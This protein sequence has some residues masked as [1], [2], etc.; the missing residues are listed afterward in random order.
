MVNKEEQMGM[1]KIDLPGPSSQILIVVGQQ[2]VTLF[3]LA[4]TAAAAAA[5]T[6]TAGLCRRNSGR[7]PSRDH[8]RRRMEPFA[9][10]YGSAHHPRARTAETRYNKPSA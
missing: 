9:S 6:A 5:A 8:D 7:H 4:I 3:L 2:D 1:E 10:N